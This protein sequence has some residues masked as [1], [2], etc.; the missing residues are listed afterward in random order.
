MKKL[1]LGI[2]GIVLL[3][4]AAACGNGADT[5]APAAT[6][7]TEAQS[8]EESTEEIEPIVVTLVHVTPGVQLVPEYVAQELGYFEEEGIT[9]KRQLVP[10]GSDVTNA[11]VSGSADVA[12]LFYEHTINIAARGQSIQAFVLQQHLGG[13][14]LLTAPDSG[15]ESVA[16]LEGK[17]VGVTAPGSG[18][19]FFLNFLLSQVGLTPEDVTPVGVGLGET[20]IAALEQGQVAAA[21]TL[22]PVIAQYLA[23]NPDKDIKL[24]VDTR[25]PEVAEEV[26]GSDSYP[27]IA[28]VA[29][30]EWLEENGEAARRM[31]KAIVR[32][33][34]FIHSHSPQEIL[35][36]L[37]ENYF[38]PDPDIALAVMT[39]G[40]LTYS[41]DGR[42]PQ[43]AAETMLE[44]LSA[45]NP[46]VASAGVDLS[47]T[48]TY[49]YLP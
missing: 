22:D 17:V 41:R 47:Q 35:D 49:D 39:E 44:V 4:V 24:L 36:V 18:T 40:M 10:G 32:A 43:E 45:G 16:D 27:G 30:T 31:A 20:T 19:H 5:A 48:Y 23:R 15:I 28:F 25:K 38:G 13:L 33:L 21:M 9:L 8:P 12:S 34:E 14:V 6:D 3:L 29:R 46:D 2:T 42:V 1:R 37:P 7:G 11:V 26:L